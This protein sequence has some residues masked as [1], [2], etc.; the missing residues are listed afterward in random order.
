MYVK[1]LKVHFWER[2]K[3]KMKNDVLHVE[4]YLSLKN[5]LDKSTYPIRNSIV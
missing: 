2:K 3:R 5:M 1:V 4:T